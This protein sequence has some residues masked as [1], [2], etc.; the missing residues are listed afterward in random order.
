M[1]DV[2]GEPVDN[3]DLDSDVQIQRINFD[4]QKGNTE[5]W[6]T[7]PNVAML[8]AECTELLK[9]NDAKN[10]VQFDMIPRAESGVQGYRVTVQRLYGKSPA[11][12]VIEMEKEVEAAN[13]DRARLVVRIEELEKHATYLTEYYEGVIKGKD[14]RIERL[15]RKEQGYIREVNAVEQSLGVA[16]G[17]PFY[18]DDPA[19]FP[20]TTKVN[21]V[22]VGE[23]TAGTLAAEAAQRI[24]TLTAQLEAMRGELAEAKQ[25]R[26]LLAH[27]LLTAVDNIED[28]GVDKWTL[29]ITE[30]V[31]LAF[32]I[33]NEEA[34]DNE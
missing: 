9:A 26:D 4:A 27:A 13:A 23:H 18:C 34:A 28:G 33:V 1:Q 15:D 30:E 2:T 21:G 17:Y 31:D 10:Y 19:N 22:C 20:G 16:L 14:A 25:H 7:M 6:A 11:Q 24:A 12:R 29:N 8:A 3:D 32:S 5:I